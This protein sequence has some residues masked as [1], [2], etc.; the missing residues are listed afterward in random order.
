MYDSSEKIQKYGIEVQVELDNGTRLLG[1]LFVTQMQRISD[2]LND[3]RQFIP[4]QNSDGNIVYLRKA[5]I[6][7][8]VQLMPQI[9]HNGAADPYEILGVSLNISDKDLKRTFHSLCTHY[10]PDTLQSLGLP[11]DL[12]DFA[13]ARLIRIIDAYRRIKT[14]RLRVVGNGHEENSPP[15]SVFTRV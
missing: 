2:L 12:S 1:C 15:E 14:M 7:K 6:V 9:D 5:T 11:A 4:F 8:V 13:N 3:P 10:H